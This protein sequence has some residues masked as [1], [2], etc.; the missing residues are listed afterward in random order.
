MTTIER[1]KRILKE[2]RPKDVGARCG[3][4]PSY[5]SNLRNGVDTLGERTAQK[6]VDAFPS[7]ATIRAK[8]AARKRWGKKRPGGQMTMRSVNASIIAKSLP[9]KAVNVAVRPVSASSGVTPVTT[10]VFDFRDAP[11]E[12]HLLDVKVDSMTLNGKSAVC[13]DHMVASGFAAIGEHVAASVL[14]DLPHD[15]K[16]KIARRLLFMTDV[17][18]KA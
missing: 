8:A 16:V 15:Q 3:F 1:A 17:P 10:E 5:A 6:I 9:S 13:V 7:E 12:K 18:A 4:N 11:V 14:R 2:Q